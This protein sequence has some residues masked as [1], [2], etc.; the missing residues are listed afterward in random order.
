MAAL[1]RLLAAGEPPAG[2]LATAQG[3]VADDW[4]V[5]A[6]AAGFVTIGA[7]YAPAPLPA[8]A[9]PARRHLAGRPYRPATPHPATQ[10]PTVPSPRVAAHPDPVGRP[11]AGAPE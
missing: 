8:P 4:D 10:H 6:A 1:D 5:R 7:G 9:S 11:Q 2:P 3:L